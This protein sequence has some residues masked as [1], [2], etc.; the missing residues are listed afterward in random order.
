MNKIELKALLAE[1]AKIYFPGKTK[2]KEARFRHSKNYI[3]WKA[4]ESLRKYEY[5]CAK[6]DSA[7]NPIVLRIRALGVKIADRKR[8]KNCE[9]AGIEL[10]PGRIGKNIRIC[11][12]NV[13]VN[14][15][16]GEGCVFHGNNVLG[17][18]RTGDSDAVPRLGRSVDVG[19]GAIIIGKVNIA[20]NCVIGA[21]AVVTKSFD[22]PGA[23]IVGVP[24][25]EILKKD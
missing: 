20:D 23:V 6:R 3:L 8:N 4:V 5:A 17:N 9:K 18:K 24:A 22:T 15:F 12:S 13:V 14:G 1:E 25:K 11:H 10:S 21:G 7:G 19:N 16:V 2:I